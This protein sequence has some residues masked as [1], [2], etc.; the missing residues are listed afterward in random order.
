M[1]WDVEPY[2][3]KFD[4]FKEVKAKAYLEIFNKLRARIMQMITH[5]KADRFEK[6]CTLT[7]RRKLRKNE[8]YSM[9]FINIA[10]AFCLDDNELST[11]IDKFR[12]DFV[13][14]YVHAL[15]KTD[16]LMKV[17]YYEKY[18]PL[19]VQFFNGDISGDQSISNLYMS[20]NDQGFVLSSENV[21][22]INIEC[23]SY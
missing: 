7:I 9:G 4:D 1:Y 21:N 3:T 8:D 20:F 6:K 12:K 2:Y 18:T 16:N 5:I 10:V 11:R 19:L 14:S 15:E 17:Q 22:T 23:Y 13:N